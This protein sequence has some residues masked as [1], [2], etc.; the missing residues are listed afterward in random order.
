M[1]KRG[2]QIQG[3][4]ASPEDAQSKAARLAEAGLKL[5]SDYRV[6]RGIENCGAGRP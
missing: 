1:R 2:R 5:L 6:G 3:F 4:A